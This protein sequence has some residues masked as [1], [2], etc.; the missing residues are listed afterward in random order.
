MNE[1]AGGGKRQGERRKGERRKSEREGAG[2][3]G[4]S[5]LSKREREIF[6]LVAD[7]LS[8]AEIAASL[9]LSPETV[10]THIRNAM[11]KLEA[12]T[13]SHAVAIALRRGEIGAA[14]SE[15]VPDANATGPR[16]HEANGSGRLDRGALAEPLDAALDGLLSLW[17][18]DGGWVYLADDDGLTLQQAAE[19]VGGD[20]T[21]LP[22]T[23]ALGDGA[24][25]RAALERRS[26]VLQATGSEGGAMIVAPMLD[27]GR[28][29][30]VIGLATRSSR[31][32]GRQ[33]LLLLQALAGRV[34]ELIQAGGP[35]V[36]AGIEQALQGFRT[37]W[38]SSS[39]SH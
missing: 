29:I 1:G 35:R 21:G 20:A 31:A 19:R 16:S 3:P 7:G 2:R 14:A 38:A 11:A 18:V 34:G 25:G 33:E 8:G 12:S 28:L 5:P 30:G 6:E 23:I 17:D 24:L 4:S 22:T 36:S 13:R 39:R 27:G 32:T 15:P 9:V 26:Q 10:R 37:S